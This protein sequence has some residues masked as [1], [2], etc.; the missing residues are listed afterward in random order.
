MAYRNTDDKSACASTR[1]D[2]V[3]PHWT[4]LP[5]IP[6]AV[7]ISRAT[8]C[9]AWPLA[10]PTQARPPLL[11]RNEHTSNPSIRLVSTGLH[12]S[13]PNNKT[14]TTRN[15]GRM[16]NLTD[17]LSQGLETFQQLLGS[18]ASS[19]VCSNRVEEEG[20]FRAALQWHF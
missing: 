14:A 4:G 7:G 2:E 19:R 15:L 20:V 9:D 16:V 17:K 13:N 11:S 10:F 6:V 18:G 1:Y 5:S 8:P 12:D 3:V